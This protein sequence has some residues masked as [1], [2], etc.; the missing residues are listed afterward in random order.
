MQ[1]VFNRK[2]CSWH[3]GRHDPVQL[4]LLAQVPASAR[5]NS[6]RHARVEIYM[7]VLY[8]DHIQIP[9]GYV[10]LC[11]KST[12]AGTVRVSVIHKQASQ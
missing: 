11:E 2:H 3:E 12:A 4:T 7:Y 1:G 5:L 6:V 10:D 8:T 9:C